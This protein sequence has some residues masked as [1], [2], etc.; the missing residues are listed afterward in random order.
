MFGSLKIAHKLV[1]AFAVLVTLVALVCIL[2]LAGEQTIKARAAEDHRDLTRDSLMAKANDALVEQ[3]NAV[4]GYLATNDPSFLK[5]YNGF[6]A[7]YAAA[8]DVLLAEPTDEGDKDRLTRFASAVQTFS[9]QTDLQIAEGG[10]PTKLEAARAS[11]LTAGRLTAVRKVGKEIAEQSEAARNRREASLSALYHWAEIGLGVV[12]VLTIGL[13]CAMGWLLTR[14]IAN[15]VRDMTATMR[16][17]A[18]GDNTVEV[19]A[20]GR[21]DEIGQMADAVLAF[22]QSAIDKLKVEHKAEDQR[23][24]AERDRVIHDAERAAHAREQAIVV[25]HLGVA[26]DRLAAGDLTYQIQTGFPATAA[27]LKEDF[28]AAIQHLNIAMAAIDGG[29]RSILGGSSEISKAADQLA[30]RTERQAASIEETAAALEELLATVRRSADG[31]ASAKTQVQT[32]RDDAERG[33][34]IVGEAVVAMSAIEKSSHEIEQIL[35]VIDEIAFQTNLLALNAG[36]EAARAGDAGRGFAVVAQEVRALAQRSAEAAKAIKGLMLASSGHVENGVLLVNQTGEALQRIVGG[37]RQSAQVM[38]QIAAAA[39]EQ[40]QGLGEVNIAVNQMDQVT[41]QNAAMVEES[42]AASRS[43]A[44]EAHELAR[45]VGHFTID[46]AA[47]RLA[48]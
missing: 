8:L 28:N 23:Q 31:A 48:A 9:S 44:D 24:A 25:E 15:P 22:K 29:A 2:V 26:L 6:K 27:K 46:A 45:R 30:H 47:A 11:L 33:G 12:G 14:A 4:R 39:L 18:A 34:A 19:P 32:A 13:A 41:Q 3:Q 21:S 37:V 40:S 42:T 43:L 10:D 38:E 20:V 35:S 5:R 16:S 36:V 17:L 1:A 7:D